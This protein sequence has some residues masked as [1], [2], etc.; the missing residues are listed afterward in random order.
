MHMPSS[1]AHDLLFGG[2]DALLRFGDCRLQISNLLLLNLLLVVRKVKLLI[3]V[4]LLVVIIL[5][6]L[7]ELRNTHHPLCSDVAVA[8]SSVLGL[9][10]MVF[11][12]TMYEVMELSRRA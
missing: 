11:W 8:S 5:L 10:S 1:S 9:I 2:D 7:L 6:L 3:A 4:L 12:E